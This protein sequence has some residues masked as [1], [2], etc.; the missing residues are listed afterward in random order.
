MAETVLVTGGAGFVASWCI[1]DLLNQGF[2]VRATMRDSARGGALRAA[3]GAKAP[4]DQLSFVAADLTRD[5]GWDEAMAGCAYVLHVASPLGVNNPGAAREAFESAARAGTLRVLRAAVKAS[6]KRVVMTSAAATVRAPH[7][8][9]KVSD[10]TTWAD[11]DDPALGEYRRSKVLAERAAWDF[12]ARDGGATEF[13]TVLPGAV[14]GP[15]LMRDNLGS[16]RVVE[17]LVTGKMPGLPRIGLSIV[18]VRDLAAVHVRAMTAPEAAGER[19]LATGEFLWFSDMADALRKALGA[20]AP[21]VPTRRVPDIV[22][23]TSALFSPTMRALAQDIGKRNA[24][25]SEKAKRLLGFAPRP[26]RQTIVDC[27]E[28]LLEAQRGA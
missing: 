15:L 27:A 26:A 22:V 23:R 7:S 28:S 1:V 12:M 13:A 8:A 9:D 5:D 18:D 25:S 17:R 3:I 10:E 2:A 16:V 14:F 6:V 11:P 19:F 20:R 4:V 24:T 21:D